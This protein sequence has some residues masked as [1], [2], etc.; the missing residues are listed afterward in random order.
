[1]TRQRTPRSTY[2]LQICPEFTLQDACGTLDYLSRLGVDWL[3]LSPLL[4]AV[5]GSRH[6]YNT[7]NTDR[8]D[9]ARGGDEAFQQLC[10]AAHARGMGILLDIVPNHVG[11]E[12]PELNR[13]WWSVLADGRE[14]PFA[15]F[16]DIDWE[17]SGGR[18]RIP[19]LAEGDA[20][21]AAEAG[22]LTVVGDELHYQGHRYPIAAGSGGSDAAA[23][24]A[25]QHYELMHWQRADTDLNYRRFF[26][27]NELAAVRVEEPDVFQATHHLILDA[28]QHGLVDGLRVD[29]PDGLRDPA[30]YLRTLRTAAG[31]AYTIVEKILEPGES[32]PAD[33]MT[34]GTTGYDALTLIDRVLVDSDGVGA[35]HALEDS[36]RTTPLDWSDEV[37]RGKRMIADT[38]L[39][40]EVS[41]LVRDALRDMAARGIP[42]RNAPETLHDALAELLTAFPVYRSYL[43][44]GRTSVETALTRAAERRP[45]LSDAIEEVAP[46]LLDARSTLAQRFQ[47]TSGMVMAK[48]VEDTAFY[49]TAVLSTLTEVGADPSIESVSPEE[50]LRILA[51]RDITMPASMT[52]L[53]T[54]D[55]KRGEDT[56][57]RI[58]ALSE[59]P[60]L[61]RTFLARRREHFPL[62][63]PVFENLLWQAIVGSWPRDRAALHG[64]AE[65]ASR[66]AAENTSWYTPN[67]AFER[68]MHQVVDSVFDDDTVRAD[69]EQTVASIEA[70]GWSNSLSAKLLQLL[71]P[72]VPDVYQGSELWERSLVDPDN[73][74]L[75]DFATRAE[76]LD[77]I[78]SGWCPPV[79]DSAAAKLLVTSRCLRLRR[80][81]PEA[82]GPFHRV[83]V[84]GEAAGHAVAFRRGDVFALAT[85]L[86][87]GLAR[88][89]GWGLTVAALPTGRYRDELTGRR[90]TVTASR[91]P[92]VSELL[93]MYPV[94]VWIR[95]D[96]R[97]NIAGR[98]AAVWAPEAARVDVEIDAV[99]H[100]MTAV[101]DG[102]W[103]GPTLSAGQR[104]G[105]RL[106]G[107]DALY[108][109]RARS[110]PDGVHGLA[111]V[112]D[113]EQFPWSDSDWAGL[114]FDQAVIY[115][116]HVGTFSHGPGPSGAGTLDSAITH[117]D[118]LAELGITAV[119]LLPVNGVNGAW[120]WGY[121]GVAW[122]AVTQSYG[123]PQ[124][125]RRFVDAAHAR[126]IAV[127][128]DVVY[129]HL[130]PSGNVMPS[131][132]PY[133]RSGLANTWG[134][135]VNL[136][137]P[138][139]RIHILDNIRMWLED[140]HVDGLRLDA[141]HA[142]VDTT[143]PHI[144]AEIGMLGDR[145][146]ADRGFPV[147]LIAESD[148]ND[149]VMFTPRSTGG[150]GLTAQWSDDF[151]H[152]VHVAL[153]GE[154]TGYY[155]DFAQPDALA[156]VADRGFF[157]AG[158]WSS[159]RG[160]VHGAGIR[161]EESPRRLVVFSQDHDQ[162]GNRAA[163]E[164]LSALVSPDRLAVAATVTLG[165]PFTPMLFMGEEWGATTPWQF[166]TSHPEEDLGRIVAEGRVTE[167]ERMSW[168]TSVVPNPQDPET[169]FRSRLDR[170]ERDSPTGQRLLGLYRA[171]LRLRREFD[172]ELTFG[173]LSARSDR[174]GRVTEIT[175]PGWMLVVNL[176]EH[177]VAAGPGML[178]LS[179]LDGP[180]ATAQ[181]VERVRPEE[182]IIAQLSV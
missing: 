47:Q 30:G 66:E 152:A 74:R 32:L 131:F 110:L 60:D 78:D 16:F 124:A 165:L 48:G 129:N 145:I 67:P 20:D 86:P 139:V 108:D 35:L 138:N 160:R 157:H 93:G 122:F 159:F 94:A 87:V 154:T 116:M 168:D 175:W 150:Y 27:V 146:G 101:G 92:L 181:R 96:A 91:P 50:F 6:G 15:H 51:E 29:H 33:W 119:E 141:V 53:S 83:S 113:P 95:E 123:G 179:S 180:A 137:D 68:A 43:P 10:D 55:T 12:R 37:H 28:V 41:R 155:A 40:S 56:R 177:D 104:Y 128:Q 54:H 126:G 39:G 136:D 61:W 21:A 169:F 85:R 143:T 149:P 84:Q 22:T 64:Y 182:A 125:Y 24:H 79:D 18:L 89:G 156:R 26:A 71:M 5:P 133:L 31:G 13:W 77:R 62:E 167:F 75:V 107:A 70:A 38:I 42:P 2:R 7:I 36:L 178:R 115:E 97:V 134:N 63:N 17:V 9:P 166:F 132:G 174:E 44:Y 14:S 163:G 164:R 109:P 114:S 100:P 11:V 19:V 8:I 121:D 127:I 176:S 1:M 118:E 34:E 117:L 135:S 158:T 4:E 52:T 112:D 102:W 151:H 90:L 59:V 45:E 82:F 140:F 57:A 46:L 80:D 106:D 69:V 170:S 144:L 171:L 147:T 148:L 153:T 161:P 105:F 81:R 172:T 120:N 162:I 49:R 88:R 72:G 98:H 23:V 73:R 65:K 25:R 58:T 76:L 3:Y 142:L 130:G 173:D 103:T 99:T 111:Q